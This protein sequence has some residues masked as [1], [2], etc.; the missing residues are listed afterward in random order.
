MSE[1]VYFQRSGKIYLEKSNGKRI[2]LGTGYSGKGNCKNDATKDHVRNRG[3]IPN[4]TYTIGKSFSHTHK[5]PVSMRLSPVGHNSKG[6]TAFMIHGDS[7][8]HPGEASEGCIILNRQPGGTSR[9]IK[10]LH[11]SYIRCL[12]ANFCGL[13]DIKILTATQF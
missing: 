7:R 1:F 10:M 3:P 6:R 9:I 4:G 5:G 12:H 2:Y 8:S 13:V 11:A